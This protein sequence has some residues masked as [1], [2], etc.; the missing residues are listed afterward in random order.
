M[1]VLVAPGSG[2]DDES[3]RLEIATSQAVP[4]FDRRSWVEDDGGVDKRS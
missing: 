1:S 3:A 4:Q 2:G